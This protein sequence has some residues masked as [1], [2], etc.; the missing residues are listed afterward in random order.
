MISGIQIVTGKNRLPTPVYRKL[1]CLLKDK[2]V[3]Y[4]TS[5]ELEK[6]DEA[7][8]YINSFHNLNITINYKKKRKVAEA[9]RKLEF[10]RSVAICD[11]GDGDHSILLTGREK[12]WLNAFDPYW[13]DE[14]RCGNKHLKFPKGMSILNVKIHEHH[15]FAKKVDTERYGIGEEYHMGEINSRFLTVI[16]RK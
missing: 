12:K 13:Y 5:D 14:E 2:G 11:I 7:I 1:H 6:L 15:L 10:D 8:G 3:S 16:E 9:V 4:Y